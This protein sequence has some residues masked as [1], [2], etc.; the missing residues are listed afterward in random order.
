M[1]NRT[2]DKVAIVGFAP[3]WKQAPY[4]SDE[5]EIWGL[6]EL[7]KIIPMDAEYLPRYRWF[8]LHRD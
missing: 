8:Q 7:Y 6:N 2:R 3:S 5:W 4:H 1:L